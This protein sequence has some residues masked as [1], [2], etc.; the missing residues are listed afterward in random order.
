LTKILTKTG[1]YGSISAALLASDE[2]SGSERQFGV[3]ARPRKYIQVNG[4]TIDGVS[5]HRATRRYYI[6]DNRGKQR[7][8]HDW[9]EASAAYRSVLA[10]RLQ[11]VDRAKLEARSSVR[12]A[13]VIEKLRRNGQGSEADDLLFEGVAERILREGTSAWLQFLEKMNLTADELGVPNYE[14]VEV[15]PAVA[16]SDVAELD[17]PE[18]PRLSKVGETWLRGKMSERGM[19]YVPPEGRAKMKRSPLTEHMRTTM[20]Q[21][22]RFI[23]CVGD[24]RIGNLKP[25]DFRRF[26]AWSNKEAAK[27]STTRWH[28]QLLQG[29]TLVFNYC[30]RHYVDWNWPPNIDQRI[31]AYAPRAYAPAEE[32]A[33][34]MPPD[35]FARLLS[36][37]DEWAGLDPG[38]FD[39]NTQKGRGKRLQAIQKRRDGR[40]MRLILM[41]AANG[42]LNAIDFQRL[43]WSHL[44]LDDPIPH[45]DLPRPKAKHTV[46]RAINRRTP[47]V[48]PVVTALRDWERPRRGTD[49]HVFRTVHGT[50]VN[51]ARISRNVGR[52]LDEEG[53]DRT[54]TFR[55]MR[56]IG[57]TLAANEQLP[58]E[59]IQ[60]FLGHT[61]RNTSKR[62]KG[63]KPVVYTQPIVDLINR[64]YFADIA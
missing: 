16:A 29:V 57:A 42:G 40:Q 27:R 41:L 6:F 56:N 28:G 4:R 44:K 7:Y 20:S 43:Q 18:N 1:V 13:E 63:R 34:P 47:L 8:F 10:G 61:P 35:L 39:A 51:P 62:Y 30:Q 5:L 59:M 54:Y 26:H 11:P 23:A 9:R 21:W 64:Y 48:S 19:E 55:H 25:E 31:R 3:M 36:R 32:N 17:T 15:G 12:A 22:R 38:E 50:P 37:C 24:V 49:G 45:L 14:V 58:E 52:L 60:A 33:E 2:L 53:L 46:G